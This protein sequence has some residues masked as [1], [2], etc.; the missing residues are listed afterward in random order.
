MSWIV[1]FCLSKRGG[2][3]DGVRMMRSIPFAL[4]E[5]D[6]NKCASFISNGM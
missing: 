4:S 2:G 1:G 6:G 3:W 5:A